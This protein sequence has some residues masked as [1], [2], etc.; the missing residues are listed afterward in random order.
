VSG[1]LQ[2]RRA[3]V[4]GGASGI[5]QAT[6]ALLRHEGAAVVLLDRSEAVAAAADAIGAASVRADVSVEAEVDAAVAEAAAALGGPPDLLVC[7]AGVYRVRPLPALD[8]AAWDEV[9]AIN[10]RGAFLAGR[11][12]ARALDGARGAIVNLAS[13]AA[14][15]GDAAE[16]AAHYAASKAGVVALTR[17]MAVEL[18]PAVRVNA[19][20]PGVIDTPMLLLM[21]DRAAGE[22]YL[23]DRVPLGRLGAASEVAA[24]IAFLL[25]DDA[26]YIT[27]A[28]L[29]VD[30]G[31]TAT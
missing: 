26:S 30:G 16:P 23:R 9:L 22:A 12:V 6:A 10:L 1:R 13:I 8:A 28:V 20:S 14:V 2:Q 25:S 15:R 31:S 4:T 24:A 27:G 3:L 11:A 29:P 21:E 17:Q 5:G 7:A 18:G 19:V